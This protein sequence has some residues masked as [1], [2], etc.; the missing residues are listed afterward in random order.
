MVANAFS[1][2]VH[3][4]RNVC[5]RWRIELYS[6]LLLSRGFAGFVTYDDCLDPVVIEHLDALGYDLSFRGWDWVLGPHQEENAY[7]L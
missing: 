7:I 3:D 4:M 2:G 1:T 5:G 6:S